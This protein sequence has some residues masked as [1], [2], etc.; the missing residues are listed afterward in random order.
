MIYLVSEVTTYK[1]SA[2]GAVILLLRSISSDSCRLDLTVSV[3][4]Y[5]NC[6]WYNR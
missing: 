4:A 5:R 2:I 1:G 6:R 3:S